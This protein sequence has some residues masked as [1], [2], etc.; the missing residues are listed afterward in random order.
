MLKTLPAVFAVD[1]NYQI[2]VQL[3]C[4]ALVSIQIGNKT[5][6]DDS[7]GIMNSLSPIHRVCVPMEML[8]QEKQY[9]VCIRPIVERKPYFTET[10]EPVAYRFAFAPVPETNIR[11]YHIS[12]AHNAIDMPVKAAKTF[13]NIDL[14]ILNGDV[15]DHSGDP[16]KFTN[17]Y[18]ICAQL[19]DGRVP[20]V[21]SRGN[22]D[23]RGNFAEKFADYT[24]SHHGNTY[25][26]F[27]LSSIWG[28]ILDCGE[29]KMDDHPEYGF[30]VA[31]HAFRERQTEFLKTMVENADK[32]YNADEVKTKLVIVHNPFTQQRQSPF[33]I[34]ADIY[35]QWASLLKTYVRPDLMICGHTH[36]Y[37]IHK[38]GGE[39]DHLGQPCTVVIASEPQKER[40]IGC[41]FVIDEDQ[42]EAV[43]TDS[44]GETLLKET[45]HKQER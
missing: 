12:D 28:V 19:T 30:T 6:Y 27:R 33:D 10:K 17:I 2:M 18:E 36:K 38:Q 24:P 25:Y 4:E 1:K 22:H 39:F 40:F 41:G 29:D 35:R 43:F 23:M 26:T 21:F 8:D 31:C 32:E 14:L 44:L 45:I 16:E 15:I 42:I 34:E 11:V 7:N 9:T 20:V 5:Y 13:G 3:Q 37:G